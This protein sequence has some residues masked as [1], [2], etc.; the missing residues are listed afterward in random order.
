MANSENSGAPVVEAKPSGGGEEVTVRALRQRIRQQ[1][2]LA[3]LGVSALQGAPFDQLLADTARLT[4]EGLRVEFCKILEHIPAENRL[5]VRA[6]VGWAPGIVG[7]ASVGADIASPAG[8]ALQTGKPVLSNHLEKE[9]RFRT[10]QILIDHGIH[11]AMNVILQG[12][13]K[14]YGVLEVDSK[15][16]D[17]FVVHD[18]AF[19][20]GA[21]NLLGMA[22]E[23]ERHERNMT[24]ALERHDFLRKEMN[25]RVNN[26][27]TIVVSMLRLQAR[28]ND[29]PK[30]TPQLEEAANRVAAIAR[31]HHHLYR[32]ADTERL[33]VGAYVETIC[34]D[35]DDSIGQCEIIADLQRGIEIST[36]RAISSALIVN[37][38]IANAVKYAYQGEANGRV[39]VRVAMLAGDQFSIVVRDEGI[40][41]PAGFD[42]GGGG[43]LGMRIILALVDQLKGE[44]TFRSNNPGTEFVVTAPRSAP[45]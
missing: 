27:L 39:W 2:I 6:G 24:A 10:P 25:H 26:S 12:D 1:E 32:A 14:P 28:G 11:R 9:E 19:L 5:L 4:A 18:L 22:I 42:P 40:G 31:A 3:E 15:S 21:A 7:V 29:D 43:R 17:E 34:Q 44:L 8:Y 33:D 41:L 30:F 13:G 20:Q 36:D 16:E 23:R 35:L 45:A 38:L 37:E